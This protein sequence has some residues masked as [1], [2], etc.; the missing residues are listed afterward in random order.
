MNLIQAKDKCLN[1][2]K[3]NFWKHS[4]NIE[5]TFDADTK[6]GDGYIYFFDFSKQK[7]ISIGIRDFDVEKELSDLEVVI[8][9]KAILHDNRH[10]FQKTNF[11]K[12]VKDPLLKEIAKEVL[13]CF[14][15]KG[16]YYYNYEIMLHEIDA[17]FNAL[18]ELPKLMSEVF[19]EINFTNTIKEY[20]SLLSKD[21]GAIK[22]IEIS[23]KDTYDDILKKYSL[24]LIPDNFPKKSFN[25]FK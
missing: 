3:Q 20:F 4:K 10:L 16:L 2:L 17:E 25:K 6:F 1:Y 8:F 11:P 21:S 9:S 22:F 13:L 15:N 5:I 12:R 14:G 23:D 19:P 18:K 7:T 24:L